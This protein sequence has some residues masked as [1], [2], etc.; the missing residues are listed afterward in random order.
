MIIFVNDLW[1]YYELLMCLLP[2][3]SSSTFPTTR[4]GRHAIDLTETMA[5]VG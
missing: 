2:L 4:R 3:R 1:R 5:E